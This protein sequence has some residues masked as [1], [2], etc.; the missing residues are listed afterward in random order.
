MN[1]LD[2]ILE[3]T[4]KPSPEDV[5][6]V[7]SPFAGT[8]MESC[9]MSMPKRLGD[10]FPS[11]SAEALDLLRHLLV[12]NPHK[13]LSVQQA[14]RH[15][16]VAQFHNSSNELVCPKIILLPISDNTKYTVQEYRDRLYAEI[17]NKKKA[18]Q[19]LLKERER[20]Q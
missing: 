16:Y 8:M 19:R 5:D 1:Q 3:V 12:F 7:D 20:E 17:L 10:I 4:G 6:S 2:R 18:L 9:S 11:A 15:P 13:R 14:L